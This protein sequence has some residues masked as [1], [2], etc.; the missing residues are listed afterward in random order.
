MKPQQNGRP[1]LL[2]LAALTGGVCYGAMLLWRAAASDPATN[3]AAIGLTALGG[4][5]GLRL[6]TECGYQFGNFR[7]LL[8]A[9]RRGTSRGSAGW[10]SEREARRH[11]LHK[12]RSGSRFAGVL[13]RT[14]LWLWTETH[15][16]ILG[17]AGSSK[18][19]AAIFNILCSLAD[20][21]L[22]NDTK[23]EIYETTAAMRAQKFGHRIVK[24]DPTDP[25]SECVNPLDIIYELLQAD[26]PEALT[27]LRGM[28]LQLSQEP[29]Q[30]GQNKFFRDGSRRLFAALIGAVLVV[31]RPD[32][33]NLATIYRGLSDANALH[34]LLTQAA[35]SKALNGEI[36]AMAEDIHQMAFGDEGGARTYE[37]FR[38]GALGA[39][40]PFGPGNYLARI[41]GSTT[42]DFADLKT[43][44]VTC[45]LIVDHNN[46]ETLGKWSGLMQ[47]L[48]TYQMVR[49]RNNRPVHLVLD[50]FCNAPLYSLP[51]IL[52]LLRSYGVRCIM[53]TQDL[54]DIT[55][56]YGKHAL[57]TIISET[58]VKQ[59][60]GGIRSQSTLEFLSKYLGE[61]TEHAPSYSFGEDAVQESLGRTNRALMTQDEVR[62]MAKNRQI[63]IYGNLRPILARK[64]QVFAIAPWR[65]E[66]GVNSMYGKKR[67]LLPV[68]VIVGRFRARVTR[69]GRSD[70]PG[71]TL[72]WPVLEQLWRGLV[73]A[74]LLWLSLGLAALLWFAGF[75]YTRVEYSYSGKWESPTA[76]HWCRYLGPE[77]FTVRGG[78]CPM[79]IFKKFR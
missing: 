19:T 33:R 58:D 20:N 69:R 18:S 41:T 66:I 31:C 77:P 2:G 5:C 54:D 55:R 6:V 59:F 57:E 46:K 23:G 27:L 29:P 32:E 26:S 30:E 24:L 53:A 36:A 47:W 62:R 15:H 72:A 48:A 16:L 79:I 70:V 43:G 64:V 68:E 44:K 56:V 42:F 34:E 11:G 7:R 25:D 3:A 13:G 4:L 12:M 45:Y 75:P 71:G 52:T 28:V 67:Y 37:Q 17:P 39:L 51:G 10:L 60:L 73:S 14:P 21:C 61:F 22:V 40:E 38:I 76:Y 50:E 63:I 74:K 1:S 9:W 35:Q 8:R 65:R 49:V 78:E